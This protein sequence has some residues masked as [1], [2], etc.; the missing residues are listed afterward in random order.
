MFQKLTRRDTLLSIILILVG[1][2]L[3]LFFGGR[4]I[5]AFRHVRQ[6]PP[7]ETNVELIQ[8]WMTIPYISHVYKVPPDY[9]FDQLDIPGQEN[10][11][12]S[13]AELNDEYAA[14][15]DGLILTQVKAIIQQFQAEHSAPEPPDGPPGPDPRDQE[16]APPPPDNE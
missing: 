14:A 8:D 12:K 1:L 2:G 7:R 10:R 5:R 11:E 6:G 13:I 16:P 3:V 15:E 4:A 9:I